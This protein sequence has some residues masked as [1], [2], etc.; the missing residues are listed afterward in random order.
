MMLEDRLEPELAR[1]SSSVHLPPSSLTIGRLNAGID[2]SIVPEGAVVEI[3]R[4]IVRGETVS[5]CV[6]EIA[7]LARE[8]AMA[9]SGVAVEIEPF[10]AGEAFLTPDDHPL[11]LASCSALRETGLSGAITG[12]RQASDARFFARRGVPLVIFGPSDPAVGHAPDEHVSIDDLVLAR[13]AID[14]IVRTIPL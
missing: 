12:Y 10:L 14:R 5:G 9:Y 3:D 11:V 2:V 8:A 4:R 1:R 6:D 13:R 7:E